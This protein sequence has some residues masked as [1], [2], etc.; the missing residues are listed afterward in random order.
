MSEYK[1]QAW[2][3]AGYYPGQYAKSMSVLGIGID[4]S[5]DDHDRYESEFMADLAAYDA[6]VKAEV[7]AERDA[8]LAIIE[9]AKECMWR[10]SDDY[11]GNTDF[12][13]L[14]RIL[15]KGD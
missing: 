5:D 13:K 10:V 7:K 3:I 6:E 1:A 4:Y 12:V 8:A 15:A 11:V 14:E 2:R 9:Q